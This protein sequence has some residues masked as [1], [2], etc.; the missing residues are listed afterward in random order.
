MFKGTGS[1]SLYSAQ[2][3]SKWKWYNIYCTMAM[4][5]DWAIGAKSEEAQWSWTTQHT[6]C[7]ARQDFCQKWNIFLLRLKYISFTILRIFVLL[8]KSSAIIEKC[9]P[10]HLYF[11]KM[12]YVKNILKLKMFQQYRSRMQRILESPAT[13]KRNSPQ[14]TRIREVFL[15]FYL[16]KLLSSGIE[17]FHLL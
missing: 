8:D 2:W 4:A 5:M 17:I 16:L 6:I 12:L 10:P 7:L 13:L 1:Y 11:K 9:I 15:K 14:L 3:D